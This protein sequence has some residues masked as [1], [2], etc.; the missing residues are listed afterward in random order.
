MYV[1]MYFIEIVLD[2]GLMII[3]I[4]NV[5]FVEKIVDYNLY[6]LFMIIIYL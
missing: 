5:L 3:K 1:V 2:N 6:Y 4:N